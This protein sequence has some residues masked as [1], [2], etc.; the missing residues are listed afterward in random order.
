MSQK[1]WIMKKGKRAQRG[2]EWCTLKL[3]VKLRGSFTSVN[4]IARIM[5]I[6]RGVAVALAGFGDWGDNRTLITV[7]HVFMKT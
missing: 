6:P 1:G 7:E 4:R 3:A 2:I 5:G